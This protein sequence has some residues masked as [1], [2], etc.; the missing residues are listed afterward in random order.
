MYDPL[1]VSI[2]V[3]SVRIAKSPAALYSMP[4]DHSLHIEQNTILFQIQDTAK[5]PMWQ[6]I[7]SPDRGSHG[8]G[9]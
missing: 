7:I 1:H 3:L 6:A 5:I 8:V 4:V 2:L 9:P